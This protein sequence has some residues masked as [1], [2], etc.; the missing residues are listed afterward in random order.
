MLLWGCYNKT[1]KQP[2]K[3]TDYDFGNY[4]YNIG[5]LDSAFLV[6]NR[7]V[8][9][10]DDK[11]KK[12]EAY[13]HMGEMLWA[14]GDLHG[15]EENMASAIHALDP[16]NENHRAEIGYSY[17]AL[18][19]INLDMLHY[20]SAI[21]YFNKAI[22]ISRGTDFIFQPMNGKA[23]TQQKMKHYSEAIAI[24]DSIF[25]MKPADQELVAR[26]TD[27]RA[28][29]KWL[30]EPTYP[31][32]PE[33]WSALKIRSDSQYHSGLN[34][35]YAHLSDYY[36]KA[37]PD[38]ALWYAKEMFEKAGQNESTPDILEAM[39]KLIRLNKTSNAKEYWYAA[40]KKLNDSLQ[41]S[42]DTTRSRFAMIRYDFQ[43]SKADNLVLQQHITKQRLWMY[44]VIFLALAVITGL[45]LRYNKRRKRIKQE[46]ENAIRDSRLKTSQKIH[47][48]VANGLYGLMNE[49]EHNKTIEREP[50]ITRIE[51]LYERSRDIS[52]EDMSIG[53]NGDYDHQVHD[54]LTAFANEQ[55]KV[56][57]VGNQP[58]FWSRVSGSQK[59]QLQ[60]ILNE[61]MINMKKHSHS[62]NV[63][64]V[65]KQEHNK[66]FITYKDDGV[67]FIPGFRFGNG[68]TNTGNRIKS[69]N[70]EINFGKSE[71]AGVSITISFPL[72]SDKI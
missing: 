6:Y 5:K 60:L 35:S 27:N 7:Y 67:G 26:I 1:K 64:I 20:D 13:R 48:V 50:L 23:T 70:G 68:L 28:R 10:A 46:S 56:I 51:G 52:Y 57:V 41:L 17:N 66:G 30:K 24:Y 9:N 53:N 37:N 62:K 18:G 49:L 8:N 11:L 12:G 43:K 54:L 16:G 2:A 65:F 14:T 63:T 71:T 40:Y 4:L 39:D 33:F 72:E 34:A 21:S 15:A 25:I 38:S 47:D 45:W 59:D 31:A 29:T 69:L 55:T 19:N 22:N 3:Y 32:L 44:G 61:I 36:A 58:T 42:R